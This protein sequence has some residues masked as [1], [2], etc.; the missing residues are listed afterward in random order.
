MVNYLIPGLFLAYYSFCSELSVAWHSV[1]EYAYEGRYWDQAL[2][3][4]LHLRQLEPE[5]NVMVLAQHRLSDMKS[6]WRTCFDSLITHVCET[7]DGIWLC[8]LPQASSALPALSLVGI[9]N[10][11][12][13]PLQLH[14]EIAATLEFLASSVSI[15]TPK[16]H[17]GDNDSMPS[18]QFSALSYYELLAVFLISRQ[19]F[20]QA[21]RIMHVVKTRIEADSIEND[22][23]LLIS[24]I[25]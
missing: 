11:A 3:A 12:L 22:E 21:A 23:R 13:L 14:R 4:V 9:T 24:Q 10:N 20:R 8:N 16:S 18:T 5:D 2:S 15:S 25:W 19:D 6:T 7:G 1:F 17:A